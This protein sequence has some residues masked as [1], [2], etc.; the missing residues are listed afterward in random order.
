MPGPSVFK[1]RENGAI[2]DSVAIKL[3]FGGKSGVELGRYF[4]T[5]QNSDRRRQNT[6]QGRLQSLRIETIG[7]QVEMRTLTDGMNPRVRPS[8]TVHAPSFPGDPFYARF[9]EILHGLAVRLALPP[10]KRRAVIG[11]YQFESPLHPDLSPPVQSARLG[12][13]ADP[14]ILA[15]SSAPL[16]DRRSP[17]CLSFSCLHPEGRDGRP[18]S[19]AA[20][21]R[22]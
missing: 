1:R 11:D 19:L 12:V 13:V 5:P 8:R 14:N 16:P 15:E 18:Q 3:T 4:H 20:H 9:Q 21:P 6:I 22:Q 2:P 17:A 7:V 10:R